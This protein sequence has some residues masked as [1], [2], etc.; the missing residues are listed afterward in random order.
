M[1]SLIDKSINLACWHFLLL[2]TLDNK[3]IIM[4]FRYLFNKT[5]MSGTLFFVQFLSDLHE[6]WHE[7]KCYLQRGPPIISATTPRSLCDSM[8]KALVLYKINSRVNTSMKKIK[9]GP[10]NQSIIN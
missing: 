7:G 5:W 10:E 2:Q 8:I 3:R 1:I 6:I 4:L 9:P